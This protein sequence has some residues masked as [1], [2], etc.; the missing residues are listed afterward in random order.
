ENVIKSPLSI[1]YFNGGQIG[2]YLGIIAGMVAILIELKKNGMHTI[3][4]QALFLGFITIQ[5]I[6]QLAMVF[7]NEGAKSAEI[8]TI[9]MFTLV[10]VFI[11]MSINK[12][13]NAI[14][15]LT[16]L[17]AASHFF[18]TL[19]QPSSYMSNSLFITILATVF[20]VIFLGQNE[21]NI[22]EGHL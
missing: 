18:T 2:L 20:I 14:I 13:D 12:M 4:K 7:L 16:L 15:Q 11:W 1:I 19:F 8:V 9:I 5:S 10:A 3:E 6:F 22:S 21:K 17:F